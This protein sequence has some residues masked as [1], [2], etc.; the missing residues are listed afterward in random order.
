ME[1]AGSPELLPESVKISH[2]YGNLKSYRS[3]LERLWWHLVLRLGEGEEEV[4]PDW[5]ERGEVLRLVQARGLVPL[6]Y[7]AVTADVHYGRPVLC[8]RCQHPPD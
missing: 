6:V 4:E 7:P 5:G 3:S 8:F 2:M 1:S